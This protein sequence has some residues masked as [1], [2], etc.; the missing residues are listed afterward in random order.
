[1]REATYPRRQ[2]DLEAYSARSQSAPC[3]IC[4]V[5]DGTN[6]HEHPPIYRDDTSIAFLNRYP[7]LLGYVLVA[8]IEHRENAVTDFSTEEYL[9]LQAVVHRVG[10]AVSEVLPTERLYVLSLGSKQGNSHVHW[11]L[12]PLPPGV[13]YEE[14]Q[15][16]ALM[17]ETQGYFDVPEEDQA[18]LARAIASKVPPA[19]VGS[20][21]VT[22]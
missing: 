14:Q 2:L 8:P 7:T 16:R 3:F 1:M 19:D 21:G 13:A 5:I 18:A 11:H 20:L 10:V 9:R 15:F 22:R 12:A 4:K 6:P 17:M